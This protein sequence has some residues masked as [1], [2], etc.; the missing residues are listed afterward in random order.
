MEKKIS[1]TKFLKKNERIIIIFGIFLIL[2]PMSFNEIKKIDENYAS[3][4]GFATIIVLGLLVLEL[5]KE[6]RKLSLKALIFSGGITASSIIILLA[7]NKI[8]SAQFLSLIDFAFNC[9]SAALGAYV[10]MK[11]MSKYEKRLNLKK[12]FLVS[13]IA[14]SIF[15]KFEWLT[16]KLSSLIALF[17]QGKLADNILIFVLFII[18]IV[19]LY[20]IFIFG[21]DLIKKI[22]R[23]GKNIL[24]KN[25]NLKKA[26]RF[27]KEQLRKCF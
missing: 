22:V 14:I 16:N 10:V 13:L 19:I 27:V 6:N 4:L 7:L 17:V 25:K 20:G 21:V 12:D 3:Y 15:I 24:I 18:V 1:L 5:F 8:Y 23:M 9:I 26:R 2:I 11:A